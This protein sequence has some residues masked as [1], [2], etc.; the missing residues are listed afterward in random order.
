MLTTLLLLSATLAADAGAPWTDPFDPATW[1]SYWPEHSPAPA[2]TLPPKP[3]PATMDSAALHAG[4]WARADF[5]DPPDARPLDPDAAR[6]MAA[7]LAQAAAEAEQVDALLATRQGQRIVNSAILC[8]VVVDLTA[9]GQ[10]TMA[11]RRRLAVLGEAATA[12]MEQARI[13]P[14]ACDVY[15]VERLVGCL[16]LLPGPECTADADLAV[17]VR[18]AERLG[19]P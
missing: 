12:R 16:G 11:A 14:L 9:E 13:T 4:P 7:A 6:A 19:A 8:R 1:A 17:Q 2:V 5:I 10:S 3:I 18:A 15:P